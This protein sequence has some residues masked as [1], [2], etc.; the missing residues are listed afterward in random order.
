MAVGRKVE[1]EFGFHINWD[2][3]GH[4]VTTAPTVEAGGVEW[5]VSFLWKA[6]GGRVEPVAMTITTAAQNQPI[7][8]GKIRQIP[9]GEILL[10]HRRE[11]AALVPEPAQLD[12]AHPLIDE[13]HPA[14]D[15]LVHVAKTARQIAGG[16]P[17][18]GVELTDDDVQAVADVYIAAWKIGEGVTGAVADAFQISKSTAAK[19]IMKARAAGLLND[20]GKGWR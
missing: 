2:P 4:A 11:A 20:V 3:A 14:H 16:G 7:V 5:M 18:R 19:R 17:R 10:A 15:D 6:V 1:A 9:I 12:P 13:S 8:A